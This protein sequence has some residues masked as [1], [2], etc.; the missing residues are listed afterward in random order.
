MILRS[1]FGNE[2]KREYIGTS[3]SDRAETRLIIKV[4]TTFPHDGTIDCIGILTKNHD[5]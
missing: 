5:G 2:D 4:R 1:L 3:S